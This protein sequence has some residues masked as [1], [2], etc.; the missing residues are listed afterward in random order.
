[1]AEEAREA[2]AM[3]AKVVVAEAITEVEAMVIIRI[4]GAAVAIEAEAAAAE[5]VAIIQATTL[6]KN[7]PL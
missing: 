6:M 3:D 5:V 7:G 1:M 2:A 4:V